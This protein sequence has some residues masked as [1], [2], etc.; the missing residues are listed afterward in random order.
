MLKD[1][2]FLDRS[3]FDAFDFISGN[4]CFVLTA[5][6]STL[7]AGYVLKEE[8]MMELSNHGAFKGAVIRLWYGYVRYVI[9]VIIAVIFVYGL[10]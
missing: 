4:I 6:G 8:A 5:L 1:V 10:I 7:F 3:V 9:P 2:T